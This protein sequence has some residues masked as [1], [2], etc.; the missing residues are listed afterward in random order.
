MPAMVVTFSCQSLRFSMSLKYS[1]STEKS[2]QPGHQVGWSA[3][4]SFLVSP[5]RWSAGSTGEGTLRMF[6]AVR[7]GISVFVSL[8]VFLELS[9][10]ARHMAL[11]AL[12][13]VLHSPSQAV[14]LVD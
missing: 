10:S 8:M 4:S 3:A 7:L 12:E 2:P 6:P 9:H 13:D 14:G 11:G 5:L 1:A